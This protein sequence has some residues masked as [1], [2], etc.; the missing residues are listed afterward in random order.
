[1]NI[2]LLIIGIYFIGF[3]FIVKPIDNFLSKLV[4]KI[5]PFF[6]GLFLLVYFANAVG[7]LNI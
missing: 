2:T 4:L 3:S 7:I 6:S 5:L 1:M